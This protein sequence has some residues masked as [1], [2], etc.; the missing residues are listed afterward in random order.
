MNFYFLLKLV[1]I[2]SATVLFG[3]GMGTAFQMWSAHLGGDVR[4]IAAVARNTVRADFLFTAP[5]VIIQPLTGIALIQSMGVDPMAPWLLAVYGLYVVTGLCW[6][7]VVWIQ[8]RLRDLAVGAA[9][10]GT[11][12]GDDYRRLMRWWFALGWPAFGAV[13][14]IFWLM[15]TKPTM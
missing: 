9:A 5:A 13:L 6:L 15:V 8:I 12:L 7:P 4:A 2:L 3:T 14:A 10:A 11:P 1:H